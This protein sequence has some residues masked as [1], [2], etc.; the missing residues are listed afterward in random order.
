MKCPEEVKLSRKAGVAL[1]KR[2]E[3]DALTA[4]DRGI[5]VN[6]I[7]WYFWLLFGSWSSPVHG[8]ERDV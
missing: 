4:D 5:L 7:R 6:L 3:G 1:R 2:L 8:G